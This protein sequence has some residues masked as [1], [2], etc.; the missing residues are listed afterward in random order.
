MRNTLEVLSDSGRNNHR[1]GA[2]QA[3]YTLKKKKKKLDALVRDHSPIPNLSII[4]VYHTQMGR[5]NASQEIIKDFTDVIIP[6][7]SKFYNRVVTY[8]IR[9]IRKPN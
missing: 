8:L 2:Q 1:I 4:L 7:R 3:L 6:P 9:K 5:V